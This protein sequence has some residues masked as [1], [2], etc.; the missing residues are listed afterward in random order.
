MFDYFLNLSSSDE[1]QQPEFNNIPNNSVNTS[2]INATQNNT[3][4]VEDQL[5]LE[6]LG[7]DDEQ[8][9]PSHTKA[10]TNSRG[11]NY[12]RNNGVNRIQDDPNEVIGFKT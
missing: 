7:Y 12:V 1:K 2:A 8:T 11:R 3:A 4:V 5:E 9:S 10:Q 6:S